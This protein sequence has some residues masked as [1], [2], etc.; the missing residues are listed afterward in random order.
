MGSP[1]VADAV[2]DHGSFASDTNEMLH[3]KQ[4]ESNEL[5]L[6]RKSKPMAHGLFGD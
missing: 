1:C 6:S 2:V 4:T 3:N 5:P